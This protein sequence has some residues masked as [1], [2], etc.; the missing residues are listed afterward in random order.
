MHY[1]LY[2]EKDAAILMVFLHG[3][4][5]SG[6]MW[7]RQIEYFK[8]SAQCLVID[9][10]EQG[11]SNKNVKFSIAHSAELILEQI[12]KVKNNR[13]IVVIGFSLGAQIA[14]HMLSVKTDLIDYAMIN[15]PLVR[16]NRLGNR[17]MKPLVHLSYPF[18]KFKAF[19]RAQARTLYIDKA[20]EDIYFQESSQMKIDTLLRILE[21]NMAFE[22][23]KGFKEATGKILVTVGEK[24]RSV[25]KKSAKDVVN[26]NPNSIGVVISN[27]GHGFPLALPEPFNQMLARWIQEDELPEEVIKR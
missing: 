20:Y 26:A 24:E 15:S 2:G 9:L 27:I 11:L 3:G 13:K 12:E 6:W 1:K 7:D 22:I 21:E 5:V 10:P 25:M 8:A 18:V 14:I 16:P 17:L 23:P 19:S 4:G